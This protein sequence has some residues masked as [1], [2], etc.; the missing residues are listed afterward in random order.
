MKPGVRPV[1]VV[2]RNAGGDPDDGQDDAA[3]R[4]DREQVGSRRARTV[5]ALAQRETPE[6]ASVP[7]TARTRSTKTTV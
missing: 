3:G 7:P 5:R 1:S 4:G 6:P 2:K